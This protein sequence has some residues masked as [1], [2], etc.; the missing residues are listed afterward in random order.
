MKRMMMALVLLVAACGE[1]GQATQASGPA[2][3]PAAPVAPS[4]AQAAPTRLQ[5][6][7]S[8]VRTTGEPVVAA[9]SGRGFVVGLATCPAASH[10]IGGGCSCGS[11][12]Q[13][14]LFS[15]TKSVAVTG[16]T[17]LAIGTGSQACICVG[18]GLAVDETVFVDATV[19][20]VNDAAADVSYPN[21]GRLFLETPADR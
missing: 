10:S 13:S 14:V 4:A 19:S 9:S 3:T 20:C 6:Q 1:A 5:I 2:T 21:G 15:P 17:L 11:S 18:S 8:T 7:V 16:S 12:G